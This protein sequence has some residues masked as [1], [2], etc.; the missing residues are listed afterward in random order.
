LLKL[1]KERSVSQLKSLVLCLGDEVKFASMDPRSLRF[2]GP[3]SISLGAIAAK[4]EEVWRCGRSTLIIDPG[5]IAQEFYRSRGSPTIDMQGHISS[6]LFASGSARVGLDEIYEDMRSKLMSALGQGRPLLIALRGSTPDFQTKFRDREFFPVPQVFVPKL[7]FREDVW[8][9]LVRKQDVEDKFCHEFVPRKG[10]HIVVTTSLGPEEYEK[11]LT[12]KLPHLDHFH[13]L[14]IA[15]KRGVNPANFEEDFAAAGGPD[16]ALEIVETVDVGGGKPDGGG[17][18]DT[19][20]GE[21]TAPV[22]TNPT[23]ELEEPYHGPSGYS[24]IRLTR[25]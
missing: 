18:S 16:P 14:S 17:E 7:I 11:F 13:V 10:F 22:H 12:D 8:E 5:E 1:L 2:L 4:A 21:A 20:Q 24:E 19:A 3:I 9:K 25:V 15:D 23:S 6:H